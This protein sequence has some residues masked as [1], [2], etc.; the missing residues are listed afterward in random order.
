[1]VYLKNPGIERI[2]TV[3]DEQLI[4][5][6][7][8]KGMLAVEVDYQND[9]NAKGAA[10]YIDIVYLYRIFGANQGLDPKKKS[11]NPLMDEFIG[12]DDEKITTYKKF[13]ANRSGKADRPNRGFSGPNC[14][15]APTITKSPTC[16]RPS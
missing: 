16:T 8:K 14:R 15:P 7:L 9:P 5:G 6:F 10:M 2:G 12:W 1:M 13:I 11:F 4:A 3:S